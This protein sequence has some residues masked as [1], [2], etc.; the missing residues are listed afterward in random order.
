MFI[1]AIE[2]VGKFTRPIHTISRNYG[3]TIVTPGAAT[4]F[5][6]N[7]DSVAITCRHVM[8]LIGNREAINQNYRN[9]I[10]ERNA[11]GKSNRYNQRLKELELKYNYKDDTLVQIRE[12][13]SV[14]SADPGMSYKFINH[15]D[16]DV[17]I[18]IFEKFNN[19]LY[20]SYARFL[21]D[22]SKLQPGKTMC[23][24]G[25]PFPEFTNFRYNSINDDL[26]WTAEGN[27]QTPRF[28]IE[29][30]MTRHM[31]DHKRIHGV[32]I[33]TPGLR[34]QSGGPLFDQHG[35]V[36]GMQS[37]TNHL[38]LGFDMKN[39][40]YNVGGRKIRVNNQPFLHVGQC[41]HVDVIKEFLSVNGVKFYEE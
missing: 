9:F 11:I 7:E 8:E 6:V 40:E 25:F 32:E 16:Y 18:I 26:E 31:A 27:P 22:G 15:L 2:E 12:L 28:P 3:D 14:C 30:M 39:H 13:F 41:I 4:L 37:S 5:F 19:P 10:A 20:Q 1:N 29:G 33:S 23:R 38:H 21:K 35:I 36:C 24:L 17:S 34:G